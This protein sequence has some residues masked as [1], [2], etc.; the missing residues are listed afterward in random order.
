MRT[1]ATK[2]PPKGMQVAV[3]GERCAGHGFP[4]SAGPGGR[5]WVAGMGG[6]VGGWARWVDTAELALK[7]T[8]GR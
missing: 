5:V 3:R 2:G 7:V 8:Q 4:R 1:V 6:W